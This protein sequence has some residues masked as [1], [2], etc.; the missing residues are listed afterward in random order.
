MNKR[1]N[2][3][4][5]SLLITL[6]IISINSLEQNEENDNLIDISSGYTHVSPK[7]KS[8]VYIAILSSNDIHG[9]FYPEDLEF[10][11]EKSYSRGGL[12][13]LEKYISIIRN[14][15]KSR[16]LYF[17]AGDLF[18]G[19]LESSLTN[20]EIMTQ[21]LNLMQC[22]GST[23]GL[24]EF[25][26]SRDFLEKSIKSSSF[27]YISTNIYDTK[28]KTKNAFGSNHITSKVFTI[29]ISE[30]DYYQN[31]VKKEA[32][33]DQS[34]IKIGVVGLAKKLEKKDIT[35]T[36]FDDIT[37][38]NYKNELI[39]E[40]N[41]LRNVSGCHAVLLL[42]NIGIDCGDKKTMELNMYTSKSSQDLCDTDTELYQ[43]LLNLEPDIIDG[44]ITGQSHKQVHH[45]VSDIP[46]ISSI[47]K[48]L[49]ANILYIPFKWTKKTEKYS[50]YKNK[51]SIEGPIPICEKIFNSTKNCEFIKP[52]KIDEYFPIN[53]YLFHGVKIE[54]TETLKK[55]HDTY[56]KIWEPY[57]KKICDIIGTDEVIKVEKSG[58]SYLG[59][60]LTEIQNRM[61][62]SQISVFNM[63]LLTDNWNP[64]SLFKYKI[65]SSINFNSKICS[66]TMTGKEVLKMMSIIQSGEDKYYATTGLKQIMSK[67]EKNEFYLSQ[68][69]YFDGYKEEELIPDKEY[70]ISAIE[71]LI[72]KGKSDFKDVLTWYKA[73]NLNCDFGDIKDAIENYL[74]AQNTVDIRLYKDE[75]N[76]RIKFL[77]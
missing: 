39:T 66:F 44:I 40:A 74:T 75:N 18:K 2:I 4:L 48:G 54:K 19:G 32:N 15:F 20:G 16:F 72:V 53:Q 41:K 63:N 28:K 31:F 45:W 51:I 65:T 34:I 57:K 71:E 7:D 10:S 50:I 8:Y 69:K 73:K 76:P 22:Q 26:Y 21:S 37:F 11:P 64:G 29:N 62:G 68:V 56:D 23:F 33:D 46:V 38:L 77:N 49:Y 30:S 3:Y 13:Y 60:I 9:H 24:H 52:S 70:T 67:N 61:T 6:S 42:A 59:N 55:I 17:D 47:D 12:D 27:P 43:L 58:D 36:G 25:D 1:R 35:G 5:I 14:E